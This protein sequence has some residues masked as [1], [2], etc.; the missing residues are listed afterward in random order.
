MKQFLI[1]IL[2]IGGKSGV[3]LELNNI[4]NLNLTI[5]K[6]QLDINN[7]VVQFYLQKVYFFWYCFFLVRNKFCK[8][9]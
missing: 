4:I 3:G 2:A 5:I 8:F 9:N 7:L 1:Y 6:C